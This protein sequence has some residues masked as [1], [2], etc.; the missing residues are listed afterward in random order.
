MATIA[1]R[2]GLL[3]VAGG[4]AA[5]LVTPAV[6]MAQS[7]LRRVGRVVATVAVHLVGLASSIR[8]VVSRSDSSLS[9]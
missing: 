2:R 3:C 8:G 7:V 5:R 4:V 6:L 9:D 1:V